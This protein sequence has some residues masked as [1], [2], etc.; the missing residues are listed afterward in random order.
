MLSASKTRP[1][2]V[3]IFYGFQNDNLRSV[4]IGLVKRATQCRRSCEWKRLQEIKA[5][6]LA[7]L[8]GYAA[9][10]QNVRAQPYGVQPLVGYRS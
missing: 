4:P 9:V 10:A 7:H 6:Y 3:G 2:V 1:L 8:A 5:G